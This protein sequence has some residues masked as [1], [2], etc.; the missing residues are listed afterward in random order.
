MVTP[1]TPLRL[2][3]P[4]MGAGFSQGHKDHVTLSIT[5]DGAKMGPDRERSN[6]LPIYTVI[7][8]V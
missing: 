4:V 6:F 2:V 5:E 7:D 3:I 1:L 8:M